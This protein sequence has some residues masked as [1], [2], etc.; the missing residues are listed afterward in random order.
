MHEGISLITIPGPLEA[1]EMV[2]AYNIL[3]VIG[4]HDRDSALGTPIGYNIYIYTFN[5]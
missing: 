5:Y 3:S 2:K 4:N 1:I